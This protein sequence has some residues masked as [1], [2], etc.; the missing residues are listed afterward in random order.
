MNTNEFNIHRKFNRVYGKGLATPEGKFSWPALTV[1]RDPPPPKP[2]ENPGKPRYEITLLLSKASPDVQ[3]FEAL[4]KSKISTMTTLYNQGAKQKLQDS[5]I[6]FL[7][8]DFSD[9][10]KYPYNQG[11]WILVARSSEQPQVVG[12]DKGALSTE[13][14]KGGMTGRLVVVPHFGG[15]GISYRLEI[16]QFLQ[17][18]GTRFSGGKE[19]YSNLLAAIEGGEEEP[20]ETETVEA[21]P[22]V[23]LAPE[24]PKAVAPKQMPINPQALRDR[25][26]QAI[27]K[28][29]ATKGGKG[30]DAALD[31]L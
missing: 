22:L 18:D 11:N 26:A 25:A 28:P 16:V 29:A 19:D 5:G 8:G 31:I 21:P 3:T 6:A 7:D 30:K 24:A 9:K 2:G 12:A 17:D 20:E 23:Q 15:T 13:F 4:M 14:L 1:P 27:Q 10:E